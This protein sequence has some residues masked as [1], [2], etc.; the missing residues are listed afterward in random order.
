LRRDDSGD[1]R[2]RYG[3]L[4][5]RTTHVSRVDVPDAAYERLRWQFAERFFR[6]RAVFAHRDALR[7]DREVLD[8]LLSRRRGR[9]TGATRVRGAGFFSPTDER[10]P[11]SPAVGELRD[12]VGRTYGPTFIRRRSDEVRRQLADLVPSP[13]RDDADVGDDGYP[14]FSPTF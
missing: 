14:R 1:F 2:Y 3:V 11:A 5:N 6:E 4:G 13:S 8:L 9:M 7:D 10:S 12:R